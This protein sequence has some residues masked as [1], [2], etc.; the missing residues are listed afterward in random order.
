NGRRYVFH[1]TMLQA[2]QAGVVNG[3]GGGFGMGGTGAAQLINNT[4]SK[5]NIYHLWKPGKTAFYQS[6][7]GNDISNELYN[8]TPGDASIVNG[9]AGT[10]VYAPG[11]GWVSESGGN[12]QLASSSPGY[13]RGVRIANFNDAFT[14]A[15]PDVGAH[16]SNTASM[17]FGISASSGAAVAGSSTP[18]TPS[19]YALTVSKA[20]T[21]SG[22]VTATS[23]IN[24]GATCSSTLANGTAVTVTASATAG[25]TF[26]GWS[27]ACAG[28][29][30]CTVTVTSAT[31]VAA[32]FNA[33]SAGAAPAGLINI[34][35]RGQ[36]RTGN[37]VMIGGFVIG[38]TSSK[39]VV[40]RAR[41]PS[42]TPLGVPNA[43]G[44]PTLQLV[45]SSD[46]ATMAV[47]DNWGDNANAAQLQAS[48]FAPPNALE[49]ALL[50]GL[51]P[52]AY[53]AIVSGVGG[54]TGVGM[55]EVFELDNPGS[56]LANIST[57]GQVLTGSDVMIGGF[58]VG[59]SAPLTLVVRA[60]G[61]SLTALGMPGAL[62]NPVLQLVRSSDQSVIAVNDN[63]GSAANVAQ[64]A[65]TGFAPADALEA[66]ILVTLQ[67]GAYTAIVTGS[68][69]GTG[70]GIIEVFTVK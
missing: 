22:T 64:L 8:G 52:G 25:S 48:G 59:G 39:T 34:S 4:F 29:G 11:N 40:I 51:A 37:D 16:E 58:I 53:T 19:T 56:P 26:A 44:N 10:P 57:R 41:G 7:T 60:R 43:L 68:G 28:V 15:A 2:T 67:P 69:G 54:G 12:Y 24:C 47:N 1:N 21:G 45:R 46:Q 30:Q 23:G 9:I 38:G 35:T 32:T 3:L 14:G 50:V 55:I 13:D 33:S 18:A 63:W 17:K 70:V 6:G 61:P 49:S 62:A 20:G 27:G 36:V 42:L 5:N 65:S 31:N 66:A